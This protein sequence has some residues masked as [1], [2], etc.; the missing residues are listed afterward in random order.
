MNLRILEKNDNSMRFVVEGINTP[1]ANTLRRIMLAEVPSMAIDDV[2]IVENSSV[3]HDE[4]LALRLGLIP[5]KTD[6][7]SYSLPEECSCKSE[8]GC[9]LC[10]TVLALDTEAKNEVTTVYSEELIPEDPNIAPVSNRIPIVKLAP[11]QRVRLEAYAKLGKGKIHAKWQPVSACIYRYMPLVE[12]DSANCDACG[13]CADVCPRKVFEKNGNDIK[14]ANLIGCI[15]CKDC[16]E[17]CSKNP[18]A[19]KVSWN[20][21]SFIFYVEST[22]VLPVERVV[23]EAFKIY[24]NKYSEFTNWLTGIENEPKKK[25]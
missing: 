13:D 2:V 8:L 18:P 23:S 7:D 3:L 9:H 10:R 12:I 25:V 4:V 6:L 21:S 16:V 24:E 5:L 22:G 14:V 17:A 11:N 1:L 15:L 19:I 20:K